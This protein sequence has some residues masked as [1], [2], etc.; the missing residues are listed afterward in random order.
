MYYRY[1]TRK[2]N[3]GIFK[4]L[5]VILIVSG[6]LFTGYRFRQH[7]FFW[8]YTYNS[9][10]E[11]INAV[12]L[13]HDTGIKEKKLKKI[14]A[15]F[16]GYKNENIASSSTYVLSGRV[17]YLLAKLYLKESFT[18]YVINNRFGRLSTT[19]RSEFLNV[20]KNLKKAVALNDG[21]GISAESQMFLAES[22]FYTEYN[23]VENIYRLISDSRIRENLKTS[24]EIRFYSL[25]MILSGHEDEGL[26]FLSEKG[27]VDENINGRLFHAVV[28]R[29][30][31]KYTNSIVSFKEIMQLTSDS[32]VLK[33][34]H[35]NLGEIYYT[36]RL[37]KESLFH[38]NLA[39]KIDERDNISKIWIGKNYSAMGYKDR[40]KAIW[41]EV[42]SSDSTN[43]EAEEL[44]GVM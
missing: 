36:R 17:H 28:Q 18:D 1:K 34:S 30:A 25:I 26:K 8:K 4:V 31:K 9:F 3:R 21:V 19:A 29:I 5:A 16:E 14:I 7:L 35:I 33:L 23:K 13:S 41:A 24:E 43:R 22:D 6:L 42:L 15:E 37:Y 38:F 12:S 39:L 44:L 40:A 2:K 32:T 11:K 10:I 27:M 20:A